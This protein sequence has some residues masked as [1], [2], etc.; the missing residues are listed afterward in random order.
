MKTKN[1]P[2]FIKLGILA[3]VIIGAVSGG[4]IYRGSTPI[5]E[6]KAT[7]SQSSLTQ[8]SPQPFNGT[9]PVITL[10]NFADIASQQ[11]PAVVNIS[12]S[13]SVKTGFSGFQGF[14]QMDPNDPFYEFFRRFQ[15]PAP[16]S[17]VPT[18]GLGSGFIVSTDGVVLTNA[19]VVADADEVIVKLTDKRE[20]KAKVTGIDKVSDVAVLKI[21]AKNLPTVKIGDPQ[22]ARVGEWVIAIGSP[23]GFE[24][25]VTA[26]IISAK[27]RSLPDEGYVPFLQTDVAVNPGNSGGP[28]FNLNGEVIGINSQ[29]YSRSGGYQG[30]SFAIPID[31]AMKVEHQLLDHG[32]VSRGRL[33]VMIQEVNQQLADTFGLDKPGGALVSSVEKGGP[34]EKA[35]IEPGDVILKFNGKEISHSSDLPPMVSEMSPGTEATIEL[36]RK[37]KVKTISM[38]VGEMKVAGEKRKPN[39]E[40]KVELGLTVRPLT[41]EE[42]KQADVATGLLVEHVSDGPAAHAGIR[43]GDVILSINGEKMNSVDKL[44]SLITKSSKHLALLILRDQQQMFVPLNL[45]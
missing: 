7:P 33:G 42:R 1:L 39:S 37:G 25:T 13:G 8:G 31:V 45:G 22:H 35:G 2:S 12:V 28:L 9:T 30:L 16:Q 32:K 40:E 10:P 20:F 34:A 19:H 4:Y 17:S 44:R 24:N 21:D 41:P 38:N 27:S 11:G 18:H 15:G 6:A 14:P 23:F 43:P 5:G 3:L 36:W 26:G 29:I